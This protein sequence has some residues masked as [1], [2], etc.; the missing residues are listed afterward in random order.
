MGFWDPL[1]LWAP[2]GRRSGRS[3]GHYVF[4]CLAPSFLRSPAV[5]VRAQASRGSRI[6]ESNSKPKTPPACDKLSTNAISRVRAR[7]G[8]DCEALATGPRKKEFLE[9]YISILRRE[10]LLDV[11]GTEARSKAAASDNARVTPRPA[12]PPRVN[13][14][15]R[16]RADDPRGTCARHM[17]RA[18]GGTP[19]R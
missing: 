9:S 5:R 1:R 12:P 15:R 8:C 18:S 2:T 13:K 6:P 10:E 16:R 14:D 19:P 17:H 11:Y 4:M 3:T 7:G